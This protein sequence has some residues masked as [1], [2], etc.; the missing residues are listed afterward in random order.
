MK[1]KEEDREIDLEDE[2][3]VPPTVLSGATA[4]RSL[5][6][7]LLEYNPMVKTKPA[8]AKPYSLVDRS[9]DLKPRKTIMEPVTPGR[10]KMRAPGSEV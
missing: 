10:H 6:S 4:D 8:K 2:R 7:D 1:K 3:K 9:P 5:Q